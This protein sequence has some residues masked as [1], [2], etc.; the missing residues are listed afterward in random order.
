[1][2]GE[3]RAVLTVLAVIER[4]AGRL[5]LHARIAIERAVWEAIDDVEAYQFELEDWP[6]KEETDHAA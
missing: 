3:E 4:E 2:T 6:P 5:N 1:V